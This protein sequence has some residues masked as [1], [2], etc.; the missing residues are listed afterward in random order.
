MN[1]EEMKG[2]EGEVLQ[3]CTAVSVKECLVKRVYITITTIHPSVVLLAR[4]GK[5]KGMV[6]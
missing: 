6:A 2:E 3:L 5:D 4:P 1:Q